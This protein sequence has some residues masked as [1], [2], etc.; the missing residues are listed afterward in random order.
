MQSEHWKISLVRMCE[1]NKGMGVQS[2]V[3]ISPFVLGI[4]RKVDGAVSL[5][6]PSHRGTGYGIYFAIFAFYDAI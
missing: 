1:I 3:A 2:L 5:P 4:G 6:P